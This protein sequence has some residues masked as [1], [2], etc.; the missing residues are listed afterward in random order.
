MR[1]AKEKYFVI[2]IAKNIDGRFVP[3]SMA[4]KKDKY[5]C[6]CCECSV[7]F[8]DGKI[9]AKHF[10]HKRNGCGGGNGE[11]ELHN[12]AK[13]FVYQILCDW[14]S[15][16]SSPKMTKIC[17]ICGEEKKISI[18]SITGKAKVYVEKENE[19]IRSDVFIEG[20]KESLAIEI[21]VT[22]SNNEKYEGT[23]IKFIEVDARQVIE[24]FEEWNVT[25]T[26]FF[27]VN[28]TEC[29]SAKENILKIIADFLKPPIFVER[30][31]TFF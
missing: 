22:H 14:V 6:P 17:P 30:Q 25:E 29:K 12:T 24:N 8:K 1:E 26:N 2:P 3:P 10:A 9:K 18:A 31:L 20:E 28:H 15:G 13:V 5:I 23:G 16:K 27:R 21:F 11:S 4:S 19:G 7:V